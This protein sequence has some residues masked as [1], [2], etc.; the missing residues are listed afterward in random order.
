MALLRRSPER[1][2]A[3]PTLPV[4]EPKMSST[5]AVGLTT[6]CPSQGNQKTDGRVAGAARGRP[7]IKCDVDASAVNVCLVKLHLGFMASLL[8][9]VPKHLLEELVEGSWLPI[10]GAGFSRNAIVQSGKPP[11]TWPELGLA[12]QSELDGATGSTGALESISGF[13]QAYGRVALVDKT[14]SLVR[15]YDAQPGAAHAAFARVGFTDVITTNF[16]FLLE[17]AYEKVGRGCLPIVD[18][19]QLS[20]PNRYAGPRLIKFHGDLNHPVSMVIT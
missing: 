9:H 5:T 16:D 3:Q 19:T 13:E 15:A 14:A 1:P 10:V 20:T 11:A 8:D 6:I 12:L 4:G 2:W 17:K 7:K 18:E